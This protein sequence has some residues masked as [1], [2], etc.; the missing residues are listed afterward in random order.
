MLIPE[1]NT[2]NEIREK[3]VRQWLDEMSQHED[4]AVRGGVKVT[5]EYMDELKRQIQVLEEKCALKD[6]YL[7][8]LKERNNKEAAKTRQEVLAIFLYRQTS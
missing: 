4:I 8:K 5:R 2:Y 6:E 7:K 3:S 1:D